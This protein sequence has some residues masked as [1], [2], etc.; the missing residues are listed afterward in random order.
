MADHTQPRKTNNIFQ[1]GMTC[2]MPSI[3]PIIAACG[4]TQR[5]FAE[6]FRIPQRTIED[7][8]RGVRQCPDYVVE[9]IAYK[10]EREGLLF[11]DIVERRL[12]M[13]T[14]ID[15][16]ETFACDAERFYDFAADAG[17]KDPRALIETA[18][19]YWAELGKYLNYPDV[20]E[21]DLD[22][23]YYHYTW[24]LPNAVYEYAAGEYNRKEDLL[25]DELVTQWDRE[26]K[27]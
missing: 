5:A 4:M 2:D 25:P 20:P 9:L 21:N 13:G 8:S 23:T 7:W 27:Y 16:M 22:E 10:A 18:Y 11:N 17:C 19:R 15:W 14:R 26:R 24:E 3:K 6:Y 1:K 12:S